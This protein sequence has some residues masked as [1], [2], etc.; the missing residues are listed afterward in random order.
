MKCHQWFLSLIVI[1]TTLS[2]PSTGA[3]ASL[4]TLVSF[5]RT[6]GWR[7]LGTLITD[8]AGNLYGTTSGGGEYDRG[9]VFKIE[10]GTKSLTTLGSFNATN[11]FS[12][13]AGVIADSQGNLFGTTIYGGVNGRGTVFKLAAETNSLTALISFNGTNGFY[14]TTGLVADT[15]GNLFG[16]T[17]LGGVVN[18]GTVFKIEAGTNVLTTLT[19]FDGTN[20]SIPSAL[21]ID[22]H[23][24]L[25]GTSE[26]GGA[27][28]NGTVFEI[29]AGTNVLT[30][31]ASFDGTNGDRPRGLVVDD[32]GNLYGIT[33]LG[34]TNDKGTV[35]KIAA[36][37]NVL[38][39]LVSF[40]GTNGA[41]PLGD[42]I[43]D[44]QGNL[45][46]TTVAG[47]AINAGTVFKVEAGTNVL[48]TLVSFD[49]TN[50]ALPVGG[51]VADAAGNLFGTTYQGGLYYE[52][53]VFQLS[54]TGFIVVPEVPS[55]AL[56]SVGVLG[57]AI[58][59]SRKFKGSAA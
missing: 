14:P 51:L 30:I 36:G 5:N 3:G 28:G 58:L 39:T 47:G 40:D 56:G 22:I 24:N 45:F 1:L 31:I 29:A 11:G 9:T 6:N 37:T 43:V 48:T 23:G 34:G 25:Y 52:G 59:Y 17:D 32:I 35:F 18:A 42:L 41:S 21:L 20:L 10:S 2:H 27:N 16:T 57:L 49:G 53:T 44:A 15:A 12:P 8:S 54:D 55:L 33:G 50:G 26:F 46:G 4:S 19:S 13:R 7:P 38:T